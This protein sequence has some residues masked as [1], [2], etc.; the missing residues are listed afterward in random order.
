MSTDVTITSTGAATAQRLAVLEAV[1][2]NGLRTFIEVGNAL[3]EI[4]NDRLYREQG[5]ATF[6]DYCRKRWGWGRNYVN[7]QI[8]AAE[9]VKNLGT[10]VPNVITERQAREL[11]RLPAEQQR[12]VA[13]TIDFNHTTA[14]EVR[15]AVELHVLQ[16]ERRP[17]RTVIT[18]SEWNAMSARQK[19]LALHYPRSRTAQFNRQ[20]ND[21]VE[22]ARNTDNPVTGC[23]H[24][25]NYCYARDIAE[26]FYSHGF[27]PAFIPE[28]LSAAANTPVPVQAKDDI[29][30]RNVFVC[31]MADLF[32]KWVP[33]EW[34]EAV[35]EEARANPQWNFLYLTKFPHRMAEFK[36]PPNAWL[37][38][39]VDTQARADIA[40]KAM[41]KIEASVR[42]VSIEPMLEWVRLDFSLFDWAVI[43]GASRSSQTPE[44]R[45]PWS[46]ICGVTSDALQAGCAVYHK[47]NL[48]PGRLREYPGGTIMDE[49][50]PPEEF[51][52]RS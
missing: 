2:Q 26:R 48:F 50:R 36:Y 3:L 10:T 1:I 24:N 45:P 49:P 34:I 44:W 15:T 37:G 47:A 32:G 35:L 13:A 20:Y 19:H 22:W 17:V 27:E 30:Y 40:Q 29:A 14:A 38:T 9:V 8:A 12:E 39:S 18:I 11:V 46:W 5:F 42:W 43:G 16:P 6:E 25:C 4:R 31:S 33:T 41:S 7:K 28:I 23:L 51:G 21:S 52:L